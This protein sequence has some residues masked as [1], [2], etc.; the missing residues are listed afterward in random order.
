MKKIVD[1]QCLP[2]YRLSLL[3][4]KK[5]QRTKRTNYC[6]IK[7]IDIIVVSHYLLPS[8]VMFYPH[9]QWIDELQNSR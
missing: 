6:W 9:T 8:M 4:T 5:N 7:G 2:V 3:R 1:A